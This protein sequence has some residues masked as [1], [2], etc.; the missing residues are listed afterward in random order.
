MRAGCTEEKSL[1]D[2]CL[3]MNSPA[4]VW[5]RSLEPEDTPLSSICELLLV[6]LFYKVAVC[7]HKLGQILKG[8]VMLSSEV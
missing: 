5:H 2:F 3:K 7:T 1:Q 8:R 6:I 4:D